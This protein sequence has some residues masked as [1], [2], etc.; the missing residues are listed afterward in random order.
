MYLKVNLLFVV[1]KSVGSSKP[2]D[3]IA[4]SIPAKC[5]KKDRHFHVFLKSQTFKLQPRGRRSILRAKNYVKLPVTSYL[6][7]AIF[8]EIISGIKN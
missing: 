3:L 4:I 8:D 2:E 5:Q 1:R 6:L 7:A